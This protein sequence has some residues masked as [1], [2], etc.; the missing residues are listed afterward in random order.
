MWR[1]ACISVALAALAATG[2]S[3]AGEAKTSAKLP[4]TTVARGTSNGGFGPSRPQAFVSTDSRFVY[5]YAYAGQFPSSGFG[6]SINK[7]TLVRGQFRVFG[8][9]TV[10]GLTVTGSSLPYHFIRIRRESVRGPI[11]RSALLVQVQAG[12]QAHT[13]VAH[14]SSAPLGVPTFGVRLRSATLMRRPET[15]WTWTG[16]GRLE[17]DPFWFLYLEGSIHFG[18]YETQT[19]YYLMDDATGHIFGFG[20][21]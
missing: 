18:P 8:D 16:G 14:L 10:P 6:L 5:V 17:A 3:A 9:L 20:S 21:P 4:F 15:L 7:V 1:R 12:L 2:P 19:G 13:G 11:P